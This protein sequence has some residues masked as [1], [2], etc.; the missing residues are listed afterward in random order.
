VISTTQKFSKYQII[1]WPDQETQH[2]GQRESISSFLPFSNKQL[3]K[4]WVR[5]PGIIT[6]PGLQHAAPQNEKGWDGNAYPRS[7][8]WSFGSEQQEQ[9]CLEFGR[10]QVKLPSLN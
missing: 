10:K 8:G 9:L 3:H 5:T 4:T 1:R 2:A 7:L 6:L